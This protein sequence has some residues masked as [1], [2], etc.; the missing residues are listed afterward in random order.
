VRR[1]MNC[2]NGWSQGQ[3][4][5]DVIPTQ[6]GHQTLASKKDSKPSAL[7]RSAR[8]LPL[9]DSIQVSHQR[10]SA[11]IRPTAGPHHLAVVPLSICQ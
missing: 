4:T 5:T 2:A 3:R 1:W 9:N 7:S 6:V 11:S 8:S 10:K